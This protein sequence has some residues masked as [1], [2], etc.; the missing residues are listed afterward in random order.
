[1]ERCPLQVYWCNGA[2]ICAPH[3]QEMVR[4]IEEELQPWSASC[5]AEEEAQL[6]PL[7]T[8]PL[9]HINLCYMEELQSLCFHRDLNRASP[10]KF[11]HSSFHGVGHVFVQKAFEAFGFAPPLAVPEQRD[12]DPEFPSLRC[13]NPEEGAPALEL[14]LLLAERE[15]A[16]IVLATDPDAD[17]LAAAERCDRYGL[18]EGA[19]SMEQSSDAASAPVAC[20]EKLVHV[21]GQQGLSFIKHLF[22]NFFWLLE[23]RPEI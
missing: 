7:R 2:Q 3:D 16:H 18:L 19:W 13:P 20:S 10:L 23:I 11:V 4:S 22:S 17:R 6:H 12:P 9:P 1:M 15:G 8:D 21:N 14:S 5:W